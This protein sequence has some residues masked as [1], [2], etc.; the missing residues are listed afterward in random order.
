LMY[1]KSMLFNSNIAKWWHN[2]ALRKKLLEAELRI[3]SGVTDTI[4]E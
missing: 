3:I 2:C 4:L 1:A